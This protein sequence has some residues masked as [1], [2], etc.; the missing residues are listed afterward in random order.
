MQC[1]CA[2][3]KSSFGF[4]FDAVEPSSKHSDRSPY[5]G[6]LLDGFFPYVSSDL[7][8]RFSVSDASRCWPDQGTPNAGSWRLNGS[9]SAG[10]GA[11]PQHLQH[12]QRLVRVASHPFQRPCLGEPSAS[13]SIAV[14]KPISS[15]NWWWRHLLPETNIRNGDNIGNTFGCQMKTTH[16]CAAKFLSLRHYS[17]SVRLSLCLCRCRCRCLCLCMSLSICIS[18]YPQNDRH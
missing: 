2:C 12:R 15:N 14:E 5:T 4:H 16:A 1:S 9:Y 6:S 18:L 8:V 13:T 7:A 10:D 17:V 3:M 11:C